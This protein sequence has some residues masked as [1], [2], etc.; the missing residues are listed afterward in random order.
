MYQKVIKY[1][2]KLLTHWSSGLLTGLS[3]EQASGLC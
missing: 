2:R 3:P 1:V